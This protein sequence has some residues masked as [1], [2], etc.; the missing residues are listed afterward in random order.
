LNKDEN[1]STKSTR[2]VKANVNTQKEN[3]N[4][5]NNNNIGKGIMLKGHPLSSDGAA[6]HGRDEE[7]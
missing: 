5:D 2:H 3:E 4:R 1:P 6:L 7:L